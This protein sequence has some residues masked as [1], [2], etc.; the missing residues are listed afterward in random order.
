MQ[1]EDLSTGRADSGLPG[2]GRAPRRG[3]D[4]LD[5]AADRLDESSWEQFDESPPAAGRSHNLLDGEDLGR[6]RA[7]LERQLRDRPLPT[8]LLCVAAGWLAGK[9]LR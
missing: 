3:V 2:A 8:L 9:L 6:I 4:A 5:D 1:N 7:V